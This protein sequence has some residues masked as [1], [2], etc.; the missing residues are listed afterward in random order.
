MFRMFVAWIWAFFL[1]QYSTVYGFF[2][3][4]LLFV[5]VLARHMENRVRTNSIARMIHT[6]F[7]FKL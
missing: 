6:F 5:Y 2:V 3:F 1:F 4:D 7:F